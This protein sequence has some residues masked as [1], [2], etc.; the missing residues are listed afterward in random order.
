MFAIQNGLESPR[1]YRRDIIALMAYPHFYSNHGISSC[2]QRL[3]DGIKDE[4][5]HNLYMD[6]DDH[7]RRGMT[8][9]VCRNPLKNHYQVSST[10]S[11]DTRTFS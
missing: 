8:Q 3:R 7:K 11:N 5:C 4:R 6:H 2:R 1:L 9:Y 10:F